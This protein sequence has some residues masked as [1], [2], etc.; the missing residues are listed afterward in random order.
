MLP[1]ELI[2]AAII[3]AIPIILY[4]NAATTIEALN[5]KKL[6][7]CIKAHIFLMAII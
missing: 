4:V 5:N 6:T 7:N 2:V 3:P 1:I